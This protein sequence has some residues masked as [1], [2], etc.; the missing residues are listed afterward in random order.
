MER[1]VREDESLRPA[2]AALN[3]PEMLTVLTLVRT[4]SSARFIMSREKLETIFRPLAI[5]ALKLAAVA[6]AFSVFGQIAARQAFVPWPIAHC[7]V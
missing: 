1:S 4:W 3:P 2:A 6:A 7:L 5:I